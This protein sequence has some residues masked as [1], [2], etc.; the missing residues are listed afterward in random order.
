MCSGGVQ[1]EVAGRG[2]RRYIWMGA[3][4]LLMVRWSGVVGAIC[5]YQMFSS[6]TLS[7]F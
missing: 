7:A 1:W 3:A 2:E 6:P 4:G 5:H